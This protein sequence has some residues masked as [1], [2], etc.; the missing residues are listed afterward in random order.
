MAVRQAG[1]VEIIAFAGRIVSGDGAGAVREAIKGAVERGH[2]NIL[3]D[4]GG[5][6]TI[7]SMGLGEISAA[8]IT[9]ARLGGAMKL[10]NPQA[11]VSSLLQITHLYSV[12][13]TFS[14]ENAAVASFD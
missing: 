9:V 3:L 6:R 14:D 7:D 12:L 11:K 5:V 2:R 1:N 10:L 13:V 8:Y 4:L